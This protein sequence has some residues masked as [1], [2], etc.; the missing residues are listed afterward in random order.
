MI[1]IAIIGVIVSLANPLD[2]QCVIRAKIVETLTLLTGLKTPMVE[3]YDNL[4]KWPSVASVGGKTSGHYTSIIT[5]G[6]VDN[7]EKFYV[8]ATMKGELAQK[9]LRMVYEPST[10]D[11]KCTVNGVAD[12][13]DDEF[14]PA[15]CRN[16]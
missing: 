15:Y 13:I 4:N 16:N 1:V 12:P 5:S 10:S 3:Y 2:S 6:A 8:E 7:E 14:L 11:W 9:Q